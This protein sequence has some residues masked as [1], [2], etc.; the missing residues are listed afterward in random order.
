MPA[1]V[2]LEAVFAGP[3]EQGQ[4]GQPSHLPESSALAQVQL[5]PW[6][7]RDRTRTN[8]A[9]QDR[10]DVTQNITQQDPVSQKKSPTLT[11]VPASD[12][13][14]E[15][16]TYSTSSQRRP[17]RSS[18]LPYRPSRKPGR[19]LHVRTPP[20]HLVSGNSVHR[21]GRGHFVD[22]LVLRNAQEPERE[23]AKVRVCARK[24][25]EAEEREGRRSG[26]HAE[27]AV[28]KTK[29]DSSSVTKKQEA[30]AAQK[31]QQSQQQE[32]AAVPTCQ[33]PSSTPTLTRKSGIKI[34]TT[35]A[36]PPLARPTTLGP[37]WLHAAASVG[38]AAL[39]PHHY[40]LFQTPRP[41]RPHGNRDRS[42]MFG[43]ASSPYS[44]TMWRKCRRRE[45]KRRKINGKKLKRKRV[46]QVSRDKRIE[47]RPKGNLKK[48][49]AEKEKGKD[50]DKGKGS[51]KSEKSKRKSRDL[52]SDQ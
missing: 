50:K 25:S 40:P 20:L 47:G 15:P 14:P 28:G 35:P 10:A 12:T 23:P 16:D 34:I 8:L 38:D 29:E 52:D 33:S 22:K 6:E 3:A 30:E 45:R 5:G 44:R 7:D 19:L 1:K 42:C 2:C 4:D 26:L 43:S 39:P 9:P 37:P 27:A 48:K 13:S 18:G 51:K 24:S 17:K 21:P 49:V 31:Q 36:S 32:V 41:H 46:G 11:S